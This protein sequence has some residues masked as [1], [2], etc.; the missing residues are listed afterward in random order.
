M[1]WLAAV[2]IHLYWNG[3]HMRRREDALKQRNP[4]IEQL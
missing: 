3:I 1:D 4:Q 2:H